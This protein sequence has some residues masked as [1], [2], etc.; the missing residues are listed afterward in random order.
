[1]HYIDPY[2]EYG[3]KRS[4]GEIKKFIDKR[5]KEDDLKTKK[6][7]ENLDKSNKML[8]EAPN[9]L[10]EQEKIIWIEFANLL[11]SSS[12]NIKTVADKEMIRQYVYFK[13]LR[14]TAWIE[15]NKNPELTVK[16]VTGIDKDGKTPKVALK[17]NSH[18]SIFTESNKQIEKILD[19]FI[20]S[21][22]TRTKK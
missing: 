12:N 3:K 8:L 18:Y 1:M 9:D 19:D 20:L 7:Q 6:V 4:E 21:Y 2:D 10:N 14:D 15:W 16:I 17:E 11:I 5:K 22:K 13:V